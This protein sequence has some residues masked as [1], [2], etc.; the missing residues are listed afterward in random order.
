MID[1]E[2]TY[3]SIRTI[4]QTVSG[5]GDADV[6]V[7]YKGTAY[8]VTQPWLAKVEIRECKHETHDGALIGLLAILKRE[9]A[10]K[11]KSAENEAT[12]LRQALN[13]LGN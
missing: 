5:K 12:R 6:T 13:Q 4:Y 3:K 11:T 2:A 8:G 9:L 1:V 7:T 10:D